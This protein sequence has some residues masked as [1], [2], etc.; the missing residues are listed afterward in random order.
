[1]SL[2][3]TDT[4]EYTSEV[5]QTMLPTFKSDSFEVKLGVQKG[6]PRGTRVTKLVEFFVLVQLS[7][8]RLP[9]KL[10]VAAKA[11]FKAFLFNN[12]VRVP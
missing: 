6:S 9:M 8:A 4:S 10:Q 11:T 7:D 12:A 1:M 2:K 5:G 3:L